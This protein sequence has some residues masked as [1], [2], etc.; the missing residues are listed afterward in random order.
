MVG[1]IE[2]RVVPLHLMIL[3]TVFE[4]RNASYVLSVDE[5]SFRLLPGKG[6][7]SRDLGVSL[8]IKILVIIFESKEKESYVLGGQCL[9]PNVSLAS[10]IKKPCQSTIRRSQV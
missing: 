2:N 6:K 1:V 4:K 3:M 5:T 8:S 9:L 7:C 10:V